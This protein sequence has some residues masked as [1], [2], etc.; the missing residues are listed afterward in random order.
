MTSWPRRLRRRFEQ[1][2]DWMEV[3]MNLRHPT[4]GC[5]F[6]ALVALPFV[7]VLWLM[8]AVA[9]LAPAAAQ[10]YR[11]QMLRLA[12]AQDTVALCLYA[13]VVLHCLPRYRSARPRPW[14]AYGLITLVLAGATNVALLYGHKDTPMALIFLAAFVLVRMWFPLRLLAPGLLL[15]ALMIGAAEILIRAGSLPYAPLLSRPVVTGEGLAWWWGI[16]MRVIFDM[17]VIFFSTMMFFMFA[18]LERRNRA[19]EMLAHTDTLTG[20]LNRAS[21]MQRLAEECARQARNRR[22][23]CVMMCDLDHFKQVN[24]RYGHP[25]GD[26]VLARLGELLRDTVRQPLDIPA[27]LGGEEFAVL[28]PETDLEAARGVARRLAA[29]LRRQAFESGGQR[30]TV[31]LS[32]GIVESAGGDGEKA[33]RLADA[34]LYQAKAEGR[35]RVVATVAA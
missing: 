34:N 30:F 6:I 17:A 8:D 16:W 24:D 18:I 1:A 11:P 9:L 29:G 28:L 5:L 26:A 31:T 21:F 25:A 32:I 19:L 10:F 13:G 35:D 4:A 3:Q 15:S 33:L 22:A 14:L 7:F 23:F 12:F 27:R 2:L 20:L